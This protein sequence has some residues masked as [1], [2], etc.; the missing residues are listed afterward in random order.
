MDEIISENITNYQTI[1]QCGF[2]KIPD[3]CYINI[4]GKLYVPLPKELR[5]SAKGL[6]N[7]KNK[8]NK[9]FNPQDKY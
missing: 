1:L 8:D 2:Q 4:K 6:I 5:N 9:H 7:I 3:G